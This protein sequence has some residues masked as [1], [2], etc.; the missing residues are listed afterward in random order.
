MGSQERFF[1]QTTQDTVA[2]YYRLPI[3]QF[4]LSSKSKIFAYCKEIGFLDLEYDTQEK[5]REGL[6][7][8]IQDIPDFFKKRDENLLVDRF[9]NIDNDKL[10]KLKEY[11]TFTRSSFSPFFIRALNE[12]KSILVLKIIHH[13]YLIFSSDSYKK[14]YF[15]DIKFLNHSYRIYHNGKI[16]SVFGPVMTDEV[17]DS[18]E[19]RVTYTT[20][21]KNYFD[22]QLHTHELVNLIN[23]R[24]RI[25]PNKYI[26]KTDSMI[27]V[28]SVLQDS[29]DTNREYKKRELR[30]IA[31]NLII[32]NFDNKDRDYVV[33]RIKNNQ[34]TRDLEGIEWFND[35]SFNYLSFGTSSEKHSNNALDFLQIKLQADA[36]ILC[37]YDHAQEQILVD[38]CHVSDNG[39]SKSIEESNSKGESIKNTFTYEVISD[40]LECSLPI[41]LVEDMSGFEHKL[42]NASSD[43]KSILSIP[44]I[45][46]RRVFA[47]LHFISYERYRFDE[48]DKRFL[49]KHS[50]AVSKEYMECRSNR[51]TEKMVSLLEGL[52]KTINY[53]YLQE[54]T[55]ELCKDIARLFSSDGA[56]VW[57]NRK[58]VFQTPREINK[59][60]ILS[61]INFL[62]TDEI[63]R[64]DEYPLLL[65]Q[66]ESLIKKHLHE[67][68]TVINNISRQCSNNQEDKFYMKY[69]KEFEDKGIC[70][71]MFVTIK[72]YEGNF[73]G[74]VMLFD[75][76]E[77]NYNQLSQRMLKRVTLHIGSILNTV[78]YA[79]Y[80]AKQLDERNLHESAQYLNIINSRTR[81]LEKVLKKIYIRD[82]YARYR[83]FLNIEDIKDFTSFTRKYLFTLF[84]GNEFVVTKYDELIEETIRTIEENREFISTRMSLNQV[85][86]AKQTKMNRVKNIIYENNI[87]HNIAVKIP[88]QAFHDI[89]NNI[90]NNAIKYG[91][92]GTQIKIWDEYTPPYYYNIYI[93]NIG[94]PIED[95]EREKIFQKGVRGYV[96]K[97][98]LAEEVEF[99]ESSFENKGLGLY[100]IKNIMTKGIK[101]NIKLHDSKPIGKTGFSENIFIIKIPFS[102][103]KEL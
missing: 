19:N 44:L 98:R 17:F 69:R 37:Y 38:G 21:I 53:K 51:H 99:Q 40:Y 22:L 2:V 26:K 43:I 25:S 56:I 42:C 7:L 65:D 46:D 102:I 71:L 61:H 70:S 73:S 32:E 85:L 58:E 63:D 18:D 90:I 20:N 39:L 57:F 41:K 27:K 100:F 23:Q 88:K 67:D 72:N 52:N 14:H 101:G 84:R 83:L 54:K 97:D 82:S 29:F 93:K 59:L 94:Y 6:A 86:I 87:E 11:L 10:E 89:I 3:R 103:T 28:I 92:I 33:T 68:V 49:L 60:V 95:I 35:L 62:D 78:S 55:D 24:N 91:K 76:S 5:F 47:V 13:I 64:G 77:R 45:F 31:T 74:A 1:F 96:T 30:E 80:R 12:S 81:D 8:L 4:D 75:K 36:H 66:D 79:T 16:L 34:T 48:V 15:I 50:S 9:D